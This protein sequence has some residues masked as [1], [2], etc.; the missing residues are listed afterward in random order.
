MRPRGASALLTRSSVP[1]EADGRTGHAGH[2]GTRPARD[3]AARNRVACA[4]GVQR[5]HR[6]DRGDGLTAR[7]PAGQWLRGGGFGRELR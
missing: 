6:G 7:E 2:N 1:A 5:K 4:I 3:S